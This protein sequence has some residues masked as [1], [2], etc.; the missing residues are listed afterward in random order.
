MKFTK[1]I[2]ELVKRLSESD[3]TP[4]HLAAAAAVAAA[5]ENFNSTTAAAQADAWM[6]W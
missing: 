5:A 2:I 6:P 1:E 3:P 4:E